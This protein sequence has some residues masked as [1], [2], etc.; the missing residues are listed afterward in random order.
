VTG[1][2]GKAD[3]AAEAL[4]RYVVEIGGTSITVGIGRRT[5]EGGD[6][7]GEGESDAQRVRIDDLE[8]SAVLIGVPGS[9]IRLLRVGD[10]VHEVVAERGEQR[11]SYVVSV[12]GVRLAADALDERAQALRALRTQRGGAVAV[13]PEV[14]RAPMPGM[15]SR[16]LVGQGD[17]VGAGDGLAVI[18]AMKMENELKAKSGGRVRSVRVAPGTAVEKGAVL[19]ELE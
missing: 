4:T 18:E 13:G 6:A 10:A 5:A 15:V 16:V 9:P 12:E 14:V 17:T 11:G 7:P 3:D 19:I 1:R 8:A 2:S